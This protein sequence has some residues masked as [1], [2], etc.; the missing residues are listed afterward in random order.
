LPLPGKQEAGEYKQVVGVLLIVASLRNGL[1]IFSI[2]L[3]KQEGS[4]SFKPVEC[5]E[6]RA[7]SMYENIWHGQ[8]IRS[9]T[10]IVVNTNEQF[11]R[12]FLLIVASSSLG[13]PG[14]T[15]ASQRVDVQKYTLRNHKCPIFHYTTESLADMS[16]SHQDVAVEDTHLKS[17]Y[18]LKL[19]PFSHPGTFFFTII[20]RW[21]SYWLA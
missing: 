3:D 16:P 10:A 12:P 2:V 15:P 8:R 13:G 9:L 19:L 11:T 1:S 7:T 21:S 4:D 17:T 6:F 5:H 20:R 14:Q 18:L